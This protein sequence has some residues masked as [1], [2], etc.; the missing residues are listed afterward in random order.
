MTLEAQVQAAVTQAFTALGN[1]VQTIQ[2]RRSTLG[3]YSTT[4]HTR[5][6]TTA[7]T[8][9]E[10][11]VT[12]DE[13]TEGEDGVI[14]RT[15][16]VLLKPGAISPVVGDHLVIGG[17]VCRVAAVNPIKPGATVFAWEVEVAG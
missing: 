15:R 10:G 13:T 2:V 14:K 16:K 5:S 17:D 3:A 11:A 8:P 9:L 7:D 6:E 4:T 12:E 1:L